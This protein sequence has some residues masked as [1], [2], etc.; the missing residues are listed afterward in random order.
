MVIWLSKKVEKPILRL[1]YEDYEDHGLAPLLMETA[2]G[3]AEDLNLFTY[4]KIISKITGWPIGNR[5]E[6]SE[7]GEYQLAKVSEKRER[8]LVFS[9]HPD[10][11]V[12]SMGGTIKRLNDQSHHISV[13][14][15]T[16]GSNGVRD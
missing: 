4:K 14:Y 15:M 2:G 13:A 5:P 7:M 8:V 9:P 12:I 11:D 1:T 16:S 6:L 3:K 10:D